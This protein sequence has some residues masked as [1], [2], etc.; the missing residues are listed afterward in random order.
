AP[1][2][3]VLDDVF[4][5]GDARPIRYFYGARTQ[6]DLYCLDDMTA[7]QAS[8]PHFS[9]M[10]VLSDEPDASDWTGRRGLVTEALAVEIGDAF[11]AEAYLCGPP[12]MIDAAIEV[13][14]AAGLDDGDI[15]FDKF[16]P[17]R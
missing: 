13:L 4:A 5:R 8:Q 15:C 1:I 6:A 3:A 14:L 9:F 11:G 10:P 7:W 16:T 12:A 2:R 17:T